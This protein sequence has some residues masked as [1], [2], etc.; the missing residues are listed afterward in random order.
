M[1]PPPAGAAGTL[2]LNLSA[3]LFGPLLPALVR[4]HVGDVTG[5]TRAEP[6]QTTGELAVRVR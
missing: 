5:W 6:E 4:E 2:T 1:K 3:T